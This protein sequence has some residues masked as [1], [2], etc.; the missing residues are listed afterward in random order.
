MLTSEK[1]ALAQ[2]RAIYQEI[3]SKNIQKYE[4]PDFGPQGPADKEGSAKSMY[5]D[6][7]IPSLG[8]PEPE[9]VTWVSADQMCA[10]G[11]TA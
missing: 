7:K 5:K 9:T 1:A 3:K 4:D 10:P 2:V 6:G 11:T 8:Y